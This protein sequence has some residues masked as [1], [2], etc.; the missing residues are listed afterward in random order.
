V[1]AETSLH[2]IVKDNNFKST[3][4]KDSYLGCSSVPS[5]GWKDKLG[6][7]VLLKV[8]SQ[9]QMFLGYLVNGTKPDT[10]SIMRDE[11]FDK[12]DSLMIDAP[13]T[14]VCKISVAAQI[15]DDTP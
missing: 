9:E 12:S 3:F 11:G 10:F 5:H 1:L 13:I 4:P 14:M 7:L 8:S 15:L 2:H 6:N